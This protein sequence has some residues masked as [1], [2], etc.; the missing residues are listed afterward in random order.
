MVP[1]KA[2][3][4]GF[5]C[6]LIA[7]KIVTNPRVAE[8]TVVVIVSLAT[9]HLQRENEVSHRVDTRDTLRIERVFHVD[10]RKKCDLQRGSREITAEEVC[11]VR[12]TWVE[13]GKE[14]GEGV[15]VREVRTGERRKEGAV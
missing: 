5:S 4:A 10:L 7:R 1:L 2:W 8:T 9:D 14:G 11:L 12:S 13:L 15:G 3:V 6:L